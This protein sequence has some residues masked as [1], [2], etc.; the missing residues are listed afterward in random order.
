[1][2]RQRVLFGLKHREPSP[3]DHKDVLRGSRLIR[4]ETQRKFRT[5]LPAIFPCTHS[6]WQSHFEAA[7]SAAECQTLMI[8]MDILHLGG[9]RDSQTR[10]AISPHWPS[11]R[12]QVAHLAASTYRYRVVFN[13]V[14]AHAA[15]PLPSY[16]RLFEG[17]GKCGVRC[18]S[19]WRTFARKCTA[20][21]QPPMT[22]TQIANT[23]TG[24]EN[25]RTGTED[26]RAQAG[27]TT[28]CRHHVI[29]RV[30][31]YRHLSTDGEGC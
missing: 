10:P 4:I 5:K 1:M 7:T 3:V 16:D 28:R 29:P 20:H 22:R 19:G 14:V 15:L 17:K 6:P 12:L 24:T 9:L 31:N 2:A 25:T 13:C 18:R 21:H 11:L 26:T 23:R 27:N 8:H 30:R